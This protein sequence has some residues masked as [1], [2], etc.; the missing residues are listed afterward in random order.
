NALIPGARLHPMEVLAQARV[1]AA[2][3]AVAA[4]V[5]DSPEAARDAAEAVVLE[6]DEGADDR[7]P[8]V[9]AWSVGRPV[10]AQGARVAVTVDHARVAPLPL[11][12]RAA[13]AVPGDVLTV[14]LSTQTPQRC[15]DDLCALLGLPRDGLRVIA[16]DVGG[17]FGGKASLMPEDVLVALA[18][19]R[20]G[21]AVRWRATRSDD[22]LAATQG[23]GAVT[24]AEGWVDGDGRLIG[25][26]ARMD[27]PLGHWMPHS[28]LAPVRNGGRILPG[29]YAVPQVDIAVTARLTE[30]PAVNIY[31]GA[32]RPEAAILMERLI[33]RAAQAA[34]ID[35]L[36]ARRRNLA[37]APRALP[38]GDR[39]CSGDFAGL[40]DRLEAEAGYSALRADQAV[41]RAAGAVCGIGLA[42]S[43]EPCGQGW[44]SASV[45][46]LPDGRIRAGTGS[47]AQGQGR[48]TA[49]AQIVAQALGVV[50]E[51]VEVAHGDTDAVP[52]GIGALASRSTPVGGAA[53]WR[54]CAAFLNRATDAAARHLNRAAEDLRAGA[55]GLSAPDGA[56][57]TWAALAASLPEPLSVSLRH[58]A[59][60]EAW[61]SGAVL[62]Q[63]TLDRETGA[64]TVDRITW[65]DDAGTVINPTLLHGQL[66]GGLAQGLGAALMERI[67]QRD[68]QLLTGSL[69][70]YALPRATDM[71]PVRIVSQPTAS[72]AN[73]LGAK[74]A[75]EA[76][77]IGVPAAILNAVQD[78]LIPFDAPDL[79]LPVT[80]ETV[81]RA[82]HRLPP[83]TA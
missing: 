54:A 59:R 65:V 29:P 5:A 20:L 43:M 69:M 34:G 80:A 46:L 44:E 26:R 3:Q 48:E 6:V 18:A 4:I 50:P 73:D 76:G 67:V 71:P 75:G 11:E 53:M 77:C 82:I 33:D 12:P 66:I 81:W 55:E 22:F 8:G 16:P 10:A 21:R 15:R 45:T 47:S 32:G 23:R 17:A 72:P 27:F 9:V 40:L 7:D 58:E 37:A 1:R 30:G 39:I 49:V 25:L 36:E 42:L 35:P 57:I 63:V 79:N 24:R 14:W 52:D 70:D 83:R 74:G 60:A 28:A 62:A 78:A 41:R 61:A 51:A 64:V 2:G 56:T 31:R 13:L 19:L 38:S 68:G